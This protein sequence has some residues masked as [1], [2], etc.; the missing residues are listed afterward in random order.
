MKELLYFLLSI[1]T[2]K[3]I[4]TYVVDGLDYDE[5]AYWYFVGAVGDDT[6][7]AQIVDGYVRENFLLVVVHTAFVVHN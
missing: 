7:V 4:S 1:M 2:G 5:A 3:I 6:V